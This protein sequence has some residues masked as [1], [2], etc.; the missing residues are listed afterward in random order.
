MNVTEAITTR[1]SIRKYLPHTEIPHEHLE[2][3]LTAAMMA[4][5]A[6]NSRP[7]S[8]VVVKDRDKLDAIR[9]VHPYTAMLKTA[10]L[11]IIVVAHPETQ[12]GISDGYFPQDC[13]AA[14]QNILLQAWELGYGTCWCGVYPNE[15]R[16]SKISEILQLTGVPFNIIALGAPDETPAPKGFFDAAKVTYQ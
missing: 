14:T 3:I 10:S 15:D 12:S 4:P 2:Q 13:G 1:R 6:C 11:A 16:R 7:W 5:S 9:E 8:F